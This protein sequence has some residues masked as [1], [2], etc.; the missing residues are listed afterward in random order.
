MDELFIL[1]NI[2]SLQG[3][4]G[5]RLGGKA[6]SPDIRYL[7]DGGSITLSGSAEE[8]VTYNFEQQIVYQTLGLVEFSREFQWQTGQ[9]PLKWYR[10]QGCCRFPTPAGDGIGEGIPGGCEII[11]LETDDE[12]CTGA[13]GKQQ[14]IQNIVARTVSEVCEQLQQ[15]KL[16]WQICSIKQYSR[17]VENAFV[18]PNDE[19]NK[20][21]EVPFDEIP[22]C[23]EFT[24]HSDVVTSIKASSEI[25]QY[26]S[27][28]GSGTLNVSGNAFNRILI[29]GIEQPYPSTALYKFD[30]EGGNLNLDGEAVTIYSLDL[31]LRFLNDLEIET[32]LSFLEMVFGA[33]ISNDNLVLPTQTVATACG[34]CDSMPRTIYMFQNIANNNVFTKYLFRNGLD[35][36]NPFILTYSNRLRCWTANVNLTG[37]SDDNVGTREN[38]RFSFEWSC[39]NNYAGYEL[40]SSSWKFGFI[41]SRANLDT[42][43]D[44]ETR[45]IVIFPPGILCDSTQN[46]NFDFSFDL[47]TKTNLVTNN[48]DIIPNT[49]LLTDQIGLFKSNYWKLNPNL[50]FR[51]SKKN[52]LNETKRQ[53]IYPIFPQTVNENALTPFITG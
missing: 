49:I 18:D 6:K 4:G 40:G 7:P 14:F 17:P 28:S 50:S 47:N 42:G 25:Y 20:L 53:N 41:A 2:Y 51:F 19:C 36:P 35:M 16:R 37:L 48:L 13:L 5:A 22:E 8:K 32:E 43:I 10:V 29:A 21:L 15:S 31:A 23:L 24:I 44:F 30:S 45:C 12:K 39:V 38:W 1:G 27:F 3:S 46:L 52:R 11:S 9:L 33:G 34:S 26:S